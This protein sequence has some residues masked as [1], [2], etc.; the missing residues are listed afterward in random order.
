MSQKRRGKVGEEE[1]KRCRRR[2]RLYEESKR[3]IGQARGKGETYRKKIIR[4]GG[5]E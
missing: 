4:G 5:G 3:Q 1:G 2:N